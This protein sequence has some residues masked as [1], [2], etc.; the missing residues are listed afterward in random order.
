MCGNVNLRCGEWTAGWHHA[1]TMW[2]S[3]IPNA[4]SAKITA[5]WGVV[6]GVAFWA[7]TVSHTFVLYLRHI[8]QPMRFGVNLETMNEIGIGISIFTLVLFFLF[9]RIGSGTGYVSAVLLMLIVCHEF[10]LKILEVNANAGWITVYLF[11]IIACT[12][13]IR[14]S[15]AGRGF[16]LADRQEDRAMRTAMKRK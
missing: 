10:L 9:W 8:A 5:R 16:R 13:G 1:A 6:G 3:D 12:N 7:A 15:W 14:G 4:T 11:I 2:F